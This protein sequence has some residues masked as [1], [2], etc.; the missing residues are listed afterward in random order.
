MNWVEL[1]TSPVLTFTAGSSTST[2][3]TTC[4]V[5]SL[6]SSL[7]QFSL[8]ACEQASSIKDY[9]LEPP[10]EVEI[11]FECVKITNQFI[12]YQKKNSNDIKRM[13]ECE[14]KL[15]MNKS[16]QEVLSLSGVMFFPRKRQDDIVLEGFIS[17]QV[18]SSMRRSLLPA[19]QKQFPVD[20]FNHFGEVYGRQ[21]YRVIPRQ[22]VQYHSSCFRR[23]SQANSPICL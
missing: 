16:L 9:H 15:N 22:I 6:D 8:S 2:S 13:S 14:N 3:V 17:S 5:R 10:S 12:K 18:I 23:Q 4:R 19:I 21:K 20:I 7:D 1:E 11:E